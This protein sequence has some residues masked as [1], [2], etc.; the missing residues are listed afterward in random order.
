MFFFGLA[1][2]SYVI[3]VDYCEFSY[4]W[5]KYH[6]HEA[7]ECGRGTF[8]SKQHDLPLVESSFNSWYGECSFLSVIICKLD[9]VIAT[10][11]VKGRPDFACCHSLE[12]FVDE[13]H[14]I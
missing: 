8:E 5:L 1:V 2:N 7:L 6:V 10:G 4:D 11:E 9:L 3:N 12:K 14:R 13:L